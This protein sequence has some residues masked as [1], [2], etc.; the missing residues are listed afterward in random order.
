MCKNQKT[1]STCG[2]CIC[3][4]ECFF[5]NLWTEFVM[6]HKLIWKPNRHVFVL[7]G[8][9]YP[10]RLSF[11]PDTLEWHPAGCLAWAVATGC[12]VKIMTILLLAEIFVLLLRS[13]K[14]GCYQRECTNTNT[15]VRVI[16]LYLSTF[17]TA[18][19]SYW[20]YKHTGQSVTFHLP[21]RLSLSLSPSLFLSLAA[22]SLAICL[23][24]TADNGTVHFCHFSF[25]PNF[26][27]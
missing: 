8:H 1:W 6:I 14:R 17:L 21:S 9:V 22:F 5:L 20:Q 23:N 10:S 12:S 4:K 25:S 2:I 11:P 26:T 24:N 15:F 19:S 3:Y 27:R 13:V 16:D 7:R 18:F